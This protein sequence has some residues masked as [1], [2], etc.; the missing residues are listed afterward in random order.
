M[1]GREDLDMA[2]KPLS[3]AFDAQTKEF[4]RG[5]FCLPI[6]T[7]HVGAEAPSQEDI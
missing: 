1:R 3:T 7:L 5:D 2:R 4:R 6:R